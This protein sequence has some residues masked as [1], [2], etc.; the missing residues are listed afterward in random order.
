MKKLSIKRF[1]IIPFVVILIALGI[2]LLPSKTVDFTGTVTE[3]SIDG[4]VYCLTIKESDIATFTVYADK[5]TKISYHKNITP[6]SLS[7]IT[8][9]DIVTGDYRS[10]F[11]KDFAK[12]IEVVY[13]K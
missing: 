9:G 2:Y 4:K 3:I 10:V 12:Y 13:R 8:V 7:E 5:K 1:L 11:N 6:I